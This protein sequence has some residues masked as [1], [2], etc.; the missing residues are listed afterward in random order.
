MGLYATTNE[1]AVL[2]FLPGTCMPFLI[3][4]NDG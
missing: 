1:A 3:V 2:R 4:I